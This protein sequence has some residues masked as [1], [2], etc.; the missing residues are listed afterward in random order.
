MW[1]DFDSM[2]YRLGRCD[3]ILLRARILKI[4][5]VERHEKQGLELGRH[6]VAQAAGRP[7]TSTGPVSYVLSLRD[8]R[9][10]VCYAVCQCAPVADTVV[11]GKSYIDTFR[12]LLRWGWEF[13]EERATSTTFI[14][15][16]S[17]V[18][19]TGLLLLQASGHVSFKAS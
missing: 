2:K 4:S 1:L 10:Y 17:Y 6:H 12:H 14:P 5:R 3:V 18:T 9:S 13:T 16:A 11:Q 8:H 19:Q 7:R 15:P